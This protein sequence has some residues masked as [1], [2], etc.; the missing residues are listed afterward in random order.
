MCVET[1]ARPCQQV[2]PTTDGRGNG[3]FAALP[4]PRGCHICDYEG[5]PLTPQQFFARYPDGVVRS[6][7]VFGSDTLGT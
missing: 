2:L 4:I 1:L 6:T 3:A 5:Q 7:P